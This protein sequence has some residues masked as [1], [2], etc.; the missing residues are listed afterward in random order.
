MLSLNKIGVASFDQTAYAFGEYDRQG[1]PKSIAVEMES[2]S[3]LNGIRKVSWTNV[4]NSLVII[5]TG[6]IERARSACRR[7]AAAASREGNGR[8]AGG[9]MRGGAGDYQEHRTYQVRLHVAKF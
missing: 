7:R 3:S 8:G 2:I 5:V 9:G 6:A 1:F 4:N